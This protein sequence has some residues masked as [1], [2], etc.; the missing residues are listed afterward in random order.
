MSVFYET[1]RIMGISM[2]GIF[3]AITLFYILIKTMIKMFPD[4]TKKEYEP[5]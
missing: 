3:S 2:V 1:L 5:E 4:K